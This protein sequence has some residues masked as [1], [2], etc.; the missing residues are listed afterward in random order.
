MPRLPGQQYSTIYPGTTLCPS[1]PTP[2]YYHCLYTSSQEGKS[3]AFSGIWK[4]VG[5]VHLPLFDVAHFGYLPASPK[6]KKFD[7][8]LSVVF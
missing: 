8:E 4:I 1:P 6:V 5:R 7:R 3:Q 2:I